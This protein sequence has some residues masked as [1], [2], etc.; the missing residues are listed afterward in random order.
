MVLLVISMG[1]ELGFQFKTEPK[2]RDHKVW[3]CL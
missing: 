3:F 1:T 2:A